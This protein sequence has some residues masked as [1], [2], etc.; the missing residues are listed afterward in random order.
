MLLT[1]SRPRREG[2]LA[3]AMA[4]GVLAIACILTSAEQ[5][6]TLCVFRAATTLP[7]PSCGMTRAFVALAHGDLPRA[8]GFNLASPLL[9]LATAIIFILG[10]VQVG[11]DRPVLS[12]L[13]RVSRRVLTASTLA[14]LGTA[15]VVNL[16]QRFHVHG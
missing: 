4:G 13:W 7:C 3:A 16:F 6:P 2:L 10:A 11:L 8:I 1:D 9:F 5:G 14:V 12:A 15:W